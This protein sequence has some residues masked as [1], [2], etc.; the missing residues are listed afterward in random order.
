M[1]GDRD[2]WPFR[3]TGTLGEAT[4]ANFVQ[5]HI[6]DRVLIS[7]SDGDRVEHLGKRSSYTYQLEA[8]RAHLRQGAP[9][10]VGPDDPVDT[11]TLIDACYER[12]GFAPRPRTPGVTG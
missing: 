5:P 3:I 4:A 9:L 11:M 1:A 12:A 7:T 8:L 6:D 2:H 10:P